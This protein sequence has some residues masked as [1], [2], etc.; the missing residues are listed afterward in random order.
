L[1]KTREANRKEI[2]EI[3]MPTKTSET[4]LLP[5]DFPDNCL[6]NESGFE[7]LDL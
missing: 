3:T 6:I 2:I 4:T 7:V 5:T 1:K